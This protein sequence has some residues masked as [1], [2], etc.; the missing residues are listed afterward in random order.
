MS[1]NVDDDVKAEERQEL[2][3]HSK[4]MDR[5]Q[6]SSESFT[7]DADDNQSEK[8]D[9]WISC[10]IQLN[11][12][13][14]VEQTF[15]IKA[16]FN[17]FW[18][19]HTQTESD[20]NKMNLFREG[21]LNTGYELPLNPS[22][23]FHNASRIDH[24]QD[25]SIEIYDKD[26]HVLHLNISVHASVHEHFEMDEFPFDSQFLNIKMRYNIAHYNLLS[27]FPKQWI[28]TIET[29]GSG[30]HLNVYS[31][32]AFRIYIQLQKQKDITTECYRSLK[33]T[34]L[35]IGRCYRHGLILDAVVLDTHTM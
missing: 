27:V 23:L 2:I 15:D 14:L 33:W 11:A 12:I 19:D 10:G 35:P 26:K 7:S 21:M 6:A 32:N 25:P 16:I 9:C 3:Q 29:G 17:V 20:L 28:K 8:K 31:S 4:D 30:L 22:T 24:F 34:V 1:S 13:S 5:Y 18:V